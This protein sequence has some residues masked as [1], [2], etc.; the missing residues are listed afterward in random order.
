MKHNE[1]AEV[2]SNAP[3]LYAPEN[4]LGVVFLFAHLAKKW[5]LRIE[6][7]KAGYPDCIVYQKTHGK[8]KRIR[9][10]FE[11]KSRN[12][13]SHGHKAK[14]CDW[15]VCWEHNWPDAPKHI[16]IVE[17]RQ[18]F[19]L[20]F[21][22]WVMP[23]GESYKQ[24]LTETSKNYWSVP[25]QAH[26]D[27]IIL[28]YFTNPDKSINFIYKLNERAEKV[29]ATWKVGKDYMADIQRVCELKAPIFLEYLKVHRILGTAGFVRG[30][31]QGRP[32]ITEYWPYLHDLITRRNPTLNRQL[33]K[34]APNALE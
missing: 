2:L 4:E 29:V 14:D 23:V 27:D 16:N 34:Y 6:E 17:L 13:K 8:E 11:F 28:F 30:Q 22:V 21:N 32:N 1:R 3:M 12:F 19:G 31:F 5:R 15:I 26:K 33:S 24:E 25:S 18:E 7:I 9:I 10:E 20:G